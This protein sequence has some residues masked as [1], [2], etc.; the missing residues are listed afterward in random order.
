MAPEAL[1]S[2][3]LWGGGDFSVRGGG[4]GVLGLAT[5]G[6]HEQLWLL[7]RLFLITDQ[8][9]EIV[10]LGRHHKPHA[11]RNSSLGMS[12]AM[13]KVGVSKLFPE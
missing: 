4:R 2:H 12:F 11:I 5:P 13:S 3:F 7:G 10:Y 1:C 8:Q 6:S 9:I